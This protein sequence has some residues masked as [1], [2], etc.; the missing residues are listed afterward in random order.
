MR[1]W[2]IILSVVTRV[3]MTV[4]AELVLNA[5][6]DARAPGGQVTVALCGHWEHD[7]P[8]RWPHNSRIDTS[9]QPL[10]LR[11]V[12]VVDDDERA[13]ISR[14]IEAALRDD[15]RWSVLRIAT[16]PVADEDRA[17]ADR[18]AQSP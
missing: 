15:D 9:T 8:C 13:E 10:R 14:M 17:L 4:E 3:A 16:G 2:G 5:G 12:V 6:E 11:T 7:G 18:L 1:R